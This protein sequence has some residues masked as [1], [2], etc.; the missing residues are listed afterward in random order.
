LRPGG[1][2]DTAPV[3]YRW[4]EALLKTAGSDAKT[5]VAGIADLERIARRIAPQGSL[6]DVVN[7][8]YRVAENLSAPSHWTAVA[9]A[10]EQ[11]TRNNATAAR[12]LRP[13]LIALQTNASIVCPEKLNEQ[14]VPHSAKGSRPRVAS[15]LSLLYKGDH[16]AAET[17]TQEYSD[18]PWIALAAALIE[19]R[20]GHFTTLAQL[21]RERKTATTAVPW[22]ALS[23]AATV[24]QQDE[25]TSAVILPHV[26][27]ILSGRRCR[28][29]PFEPSGLLAY[30]AWQE[31]KQPTGRLQQLIRTIDTEMLSSDQQFPSLFLAI[32]TLFDCTDVAVEMICRQP[33]LRARSLASLN[34]V[35]GHQAAR[36]IM[37]GDYVTARRWLK[38][39]ATS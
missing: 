6:A 18:D 15:V 17:L 36:S 23:L 25:E 35:V 5:A 21:E 3:E 31:I 13:L 24:H 8:F 2:D 37:A 30:A 26:A 7:A 28:R 14:P 12:P 9:A 19:L 22:A 34:K 1:L 29:H 20:Q 38:Q 39:Y 27:T 32:A 4:I 33:L 16:E 10:L 11:F